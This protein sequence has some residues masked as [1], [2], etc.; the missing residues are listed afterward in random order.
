MDIIME[1]LR[2]N[3][4]LEKLLIQ[5]NFLGEQGAHQMVEALKVHPEM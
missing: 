4:S 2:N 1:M 5:H 3:K